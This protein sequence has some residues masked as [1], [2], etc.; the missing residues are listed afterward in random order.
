MHHVI[1]NA[2]IY[3]KQ[4]I[5]L[6]WPNGIF[7]ENFQVIIDIWHG[8][9]ASEIVVL[10]YKEVWLSLTRTFE[11]C[12]C[13][14][15][16]LSWNHFLRKREGGSQ[17]LAAPPVYYKAVDGSKI[18]TVLINFPIY[19]GK[20]VVCTNPI[21]TPC[22]VLISSFLWLNFFKSKTFPLTI[23]HLRAEKSSST[24]LIT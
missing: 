24:I 11:W 2:R 10:H 18:K 9:N 6:T 5:N 12:E 14:N 17:P 21:A 15:L 13:W 3:A 22:I 19:T 23:T 7:C 20:Y 1:L 4:K 8:P 16:W